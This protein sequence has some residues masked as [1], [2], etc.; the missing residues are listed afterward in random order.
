VK[1]RAR[2]LYGIG[3]DIISR[4]RME[5]FLA[6]HPEMIPRRFL[7]ARE[8]RFWRTMDAVGLAE[9]FA[10]KEAFFKACNEPWMG[11]EGFR[12]MHITRCGKEK[13]NMKWRVRN[14]GRRYRGEGVFFH[15]GD[16]VG[17]QAMIWS[18]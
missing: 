2:R 4:T 8:R 15:D 6:R 11:P 5:A 14:S 3:I 10:A 18:S 16:L 7:N 12:G 1:G 17:A 13:F 9:I